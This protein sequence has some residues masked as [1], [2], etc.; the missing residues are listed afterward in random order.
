MR[1]DQ[2]QSTA[3]GK[4]AVTASLW[5][6]S[7]DELDSAYSSDGP[8]KTE[9]NR[10]ARAQIELLRILAKVAVEKLHGAS[11]CGQSER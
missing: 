5:P 7:S 10:I 6:S 4:N 1:K 2:P 3:D 8:E 11:A 9:I